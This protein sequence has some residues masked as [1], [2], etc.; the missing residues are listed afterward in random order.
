MPEEVDVNNLPPFPKRLPGKAESESFSRMAPPSPRLVCHRK[1]R[2]TFAECL[3]S[4]SVR[5]LRANWTNCA[6]R[7]DRSTM[8]SET[9][10]AQ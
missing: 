4:V 2:A 6:K 10:P 5:T 1:S 9:S 7:M 8:S 3:Q